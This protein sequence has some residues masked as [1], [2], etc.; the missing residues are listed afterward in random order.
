M[1]VG[2]VTGQEMAKPDPESHLLIKALSDIKISSELISWRADCD[3]S[4]FDLLVIR[5]PWDYFLYLEE[6]IAWVKNVE[7]HTPVKNSSSIIRWNSHKGYLRDL[8]KKGIPVVPTSWVSKNQD[9]S[10]IIQ[11]FNWEEVVIKPAVSIGAIGAIRG[12]SNQL[13]IQTHLQNLVLNG[14]VMVQP[15]LDSICTQGE[16]SLIYFDGQFSHAICKTPE[17]GDYRV[18]DA[19]G[20]VNKVAHAD[21][22]AKE[23][24][25][26][27]LSL[28]PERTL[29]AR[30]DLVKYLDK[31]VLMELE[32]IE[33]ELFLPYAPSAAIKFARTIEQFDF[34]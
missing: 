16:L 27:V 5:T 24:A 6:F 31:W 23:L 8:S 19:Y 13:N 33:P 15:F 12:F 18:Q 17:V 7:V 3:W 2:L 4:S 28:T 1:R 34:N 29:Y 21:D 9:C 14:D 25:E 11:S 26:M 10:N 30:V 20:G 32:A 22:E